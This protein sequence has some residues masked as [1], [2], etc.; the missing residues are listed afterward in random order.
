M[1]YVRVDGADGRTNINV[2]SW[3]FTVDNH[4]NADL[5]YW[6]P[7][8][9]A[10]P[11]IGFVLARPPSYVNVVV[12][13]PARRFR[14]TGLESCDVER[15]DGLT[16][17]ARGVAK[18]ISC[19]VLFCRVVSY[20]HICLFQAGYH[21]CK[22]LSPA[23]AMEW[24][25][26]DG[27]RAYVDHALLLLLLL[28]P[29]SFFLCCCCGRRRARQRMPRLASARVAARAAARAD[30]CPPPTAPA[31]P[32]S[33]ERDA[34]TG[35]GDVHPPPAWRLANSPMRCASRARVFSGTARPRRRPT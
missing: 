7:V 31:C 33:A 10:V 12:S 35:T 14:E 4:G 2:T 28:L 27:L 16:C 29:F 22:L 20:S 3:S 11:P 24:I 26:V 19:C 25:Y 34:P 8:R 5:P 15:T 21:Y 18:Y 17:F 1:K 13:R 6:I 9:F 23:R 30:T 32:R